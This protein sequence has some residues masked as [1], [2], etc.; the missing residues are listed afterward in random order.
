MMKLSKKCYQF[1]Q[2]KRKKI[3]FHSIFLLILLFGVNAY[4]WFVYMSNASIE[5]ASSVST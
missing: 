5:I 2:S 4:A 3:K 1:L